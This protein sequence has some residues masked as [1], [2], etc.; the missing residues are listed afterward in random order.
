DKRDQVLVPLVAT[1]D[2]NERPEALAIGGD[3]V[4]ALVGGQLREVNKKTGEINVL[5][6]ANNVI[7]VVFHGGWI[8]VLR[9][10]A[11]RGQ[12]RGPVGLVAIAQADHRTITIAEP[13]INPSK[14]AIGGSTIFVLEGGLDPRRTAL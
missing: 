1:G 11:G 2:P 3:F 13:L 14:V 12:P 6:L 8:Y 7:D 10:T 5:H 4:Y 9:D